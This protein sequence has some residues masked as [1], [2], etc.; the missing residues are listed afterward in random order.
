VGPL[1]RPG[2]ELGRAGAEPGRVGRL[3]GT[4]TVEAL[5]GSLAAMGSGLRVALVPAAHQVMAKTA[6]RMTMARRTRMKIFMGGG[7]EKLAF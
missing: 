4:L 6:P 1:G 3:L 5:T 7:L 2:V